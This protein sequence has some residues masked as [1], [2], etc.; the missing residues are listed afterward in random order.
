MYSVF[1]RTWTFLRQAL[2]YIPSTTTNYPSKKVKN[3]KQTCIRRWTS[4]WISLFLRPATLFRSA[5][6]DRIICISCWRLSLSWPRAFVSARARSK[7]FAS[8]LLLLLSVARMM[9]VFTVQQYRGRHENNEKY[10]PIQ[11]A[12]ITWHMGAAI[13]TGAIKPV[14][15]GSDCGAGD[16]RSRVPD[17]GLF[18]SV[19]CK[20]VTY[21]SQMCW[22]CTS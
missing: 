19:D 14:T 17:L 5:S 18:M 20:S 21:L 16:A 6:C 10:T 22:L 1:Y 12:L 9:L 2:K 3:S 13:L 8:A 15:P 7:A 11:R 4:P